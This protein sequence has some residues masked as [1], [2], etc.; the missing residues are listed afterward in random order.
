T[1]S[2]NSAVARGGAIFNDGQFCTA[3]LLSINAS[4]FSGNTANDGPT[5]YNESSFTANAK[6]QLGDTILNGSGVGGN[7]VNDQGD[8]SDVITHGYNLSSDSGTGFLTN[9]TDQI[10]ANPQL[11]PLQNNGG[12]TFT[13]A[14]LAG[15]S[16]IDK[17]K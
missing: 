9:T 15:S 17:G 7:I 10:N 14:L 6:V 5:L 3:A 12:P 2:G 1:F 4:T 16:A 13:H 8:A 11:G